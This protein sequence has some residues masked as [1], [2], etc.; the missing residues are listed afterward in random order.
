MVGAVLSFHYV[1]VLSMGLPIFVGVRFVISFHVRLS[2]GILRFFLTGWKVPKFQVDGEGVILV[3]GYS[4][5]FRTNGNRRLGFRVSMLIRA[6]FHGIMI[7]HVGNS[8]A[9]KVS[10]G[11]L[12]RK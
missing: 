10:T 8:R 9:C 5:L 7:L 3:N 11:G 4:D 6:Y 1:A 2:S 12:L